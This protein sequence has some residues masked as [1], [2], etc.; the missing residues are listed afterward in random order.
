MGDYIVA[1]DPRGLK[2]TCSEQEWTGHVI[3]EHSM[4]EGNESAVQNTISE[5][6][7][8]FE[9]H[10]S[11]PPMDERWV[12]TKKEAG[13]SYDPKVP[14]T[15]VV[16]GVCGGSGE[17]ITAYPT[18][19]PRSGTIREKEAIYRAKGLPEL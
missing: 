17:I 13:A 2:V 15:H 6:D 12:Y 7:Y 1:R 14:N 19:N 11:D 9:S 5:P 10:D 4:M 8:I 16:V 18:K 3:L